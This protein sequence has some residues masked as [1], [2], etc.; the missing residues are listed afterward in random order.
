MWIIEG[1]VTNETYEYGATPSYKGD[2][3]VK[4][5]TA[6]YDYTFAGWTPEIATVTG[7]AAYTAVFTE[8]VRKYTVKWVVDGAETTETYEYGVTPKYPNGTPEKAADAQY[9]YTFTGWSPAIAAVTADATYTATYS[10]TVN[11]YTVTFVDD[12]GTVLKTAIEY[13]YGTTAANIVKPEDPTKAADAEYTYTF[14]GWD[15]ELETV[16][17]DKT[18]TATYESTIREYKITFVDDDGRQIQQ[19]QVEYGAMPTAPA[20]PTKE[21]TAQYNKA[22]KDQIEANKKLRNKNDL[23]IKNIMMN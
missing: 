11:K 22:L 3:P 18:Y 17:T 23:I 6:Q 21:S 16:K 9:T 20:D 1:V 10:R 5:S 4:A 2:T 19:T 8:T 13:D 7:A 15:P 14:A 12:D